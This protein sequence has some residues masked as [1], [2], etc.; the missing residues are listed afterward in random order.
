MISRVLFIATM[1]LSLPR[2]GFARKDLPFQ[3]KLDDHVDQVNKTIKDMNPETGDLKHFRLLTAEPDRYRTVNKLAGVSDIK[4]LVKKRLIELEGE[5]NKNENAFKKQLSWK[6]SLE[7]RQVGQEYGKLKQQIYGLAKYIAQREGSVDK[8]IQDFW[9][10]YESYR[11]TLL[12]AGH[13][14]AEARRGAIDLVYLLKP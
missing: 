13:E 3:K 2:D 14:W 6:Q 7:R 12:A 5:V 4:T 8:D 10:Q 9:R 1:L 11:E